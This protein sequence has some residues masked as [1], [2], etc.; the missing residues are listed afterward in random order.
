[1][2]RLR[3]IGKGIIMSAL[4]VA[5]VTT[6]ISAQTNDC[7]F[8]SSNKFSDTIYYEDSYTRQLKPDYEMSYDQYVKKRNMC[9]IDSSDLYD[10]TIIAEAV[11]EAL[12]NDYTVVDLDLQIDNLNDGLIDGDRNAFYYGVMITDSFNNSHFYRY[13]CKCNE[14]EYN[15]FMD[16]R[17]NENYSS[18]DKYSG[19]IKYD[20]GSYTVIT[21]D[22]MTDTL[23]V[24]DWF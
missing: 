23:Y 12:E 8:D 5:M 4:G 20:D 13:I 15:N 3:W 17:R 7:K 2:K 1:M 21:F 16:F 9:T 22:N 18:W 10:D 24:S 19:I 14:E 6:P 11:D